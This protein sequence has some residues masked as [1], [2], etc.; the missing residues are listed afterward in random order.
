MAG[1]D[2]DAICIGF[3]GTFR[4]TDKFTSRSC[5]KITVVL[6]NPR[7]H[8]PVANWKLALPAVFALM[9]AGGAGS[10]A[11]AD[12]A[13]PAAG[14]AQS[15]QPPARAKAADDSSSG[16]TL[17]LQYTGEADVSEQYRRA[18]GRRRRPGLRLDRW[19]IPVR[20]LLQQCGLP[21]WALRRRL[22]GPERD[23]HRGRLAVPAVP[24][25]L[26]AEDRR[27]QPAVRHLRP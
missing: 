10:P 13:A 1:R 14:P 22:P 19:K 12:D 15:A 18:T 5:L 23:R 2:T 24:S 26:R 6:S 27:H 11:L 3:T 20:R 8:I 7:R 4:Y 9:L 16:V 25:L 21:E 17:R